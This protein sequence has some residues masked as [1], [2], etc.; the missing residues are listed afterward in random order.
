VQMGLEL[1]VESNGKLILSFPTNGG[2]AWV[3]N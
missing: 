2:R 3:T 1:F